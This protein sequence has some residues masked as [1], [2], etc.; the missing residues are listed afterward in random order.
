[1]SLS[2]TCPNGHQ[3]EDM[4]GDSSRDPDHTIP[5][6]VCGTRTRVVAGDEPPPTNQ[7]LPSD[8]P[9]QG[10]RHETLEFTGPAPRL[11]APPVEGYEI[12]SELGRGG[13]GVVYKARHQALKRTV[14]LKMVLG[15]GHNERSLTRFQTEAEAVARLQH[16]NIVQIYEVGQSNG[17]PFFAM[18]FVEGCNLTAHLAGTPQ[19][20][21]DCARLVATLARAMHYAH[22]HGIVHRD[23]KPANILL[24]RGAPAGGMGM[25]KITDFGLAKKLDDAAGPTRTGDVMGTPSYMAPEQALGRL[26]HIGP[27]TD[28]Y[29]L[30]A[31]L[32]ELLT[33]RP[34]FKA[35]TA[36]DTMFQVMYAEPVRPGQL[37]ARMPRDLETICLKC[38]EKEVARRYPSALALAEDLERFVN[39]EPIRARPVGPAGQAMRWARRRPAAAALV[40]V[41]GLALVAALAGSLLYNF[42]QD[43]WNNQEKH[44]NQ[45]LASLA[46]SEKQKAAEAVAERKN[47]ETARDAAINLEKIARQQRLQAERNFQKARQAVDEMLNEV[48]NTHL[49]NVPH[50]DAVRRTLLARAVNFHRSFLET[51][52]SDPSVRFQAAQAYVQLGNIYRK[53]GTEPS[54]RLEA[55]KAYRE[56]IK[57]LTALHGQSAERPGYAQALA[58]AYFQEAQL[59]R[60]VA[61]LT[62]AEQAC[63]KALEIQEQLTRADPQPPADRHALA[64]SL[65]ELG[66]ILSNRGQAKPAEKAY[67][68]ALAIQE[69]L[70]R[71]FPDRP[72]YR[73]FYAGTLNDL[74][75]LYASTERGEEAEK[76]YRQSRD[77]FKALAEKNS[78]VAAYREKLAAVSNNLG[79]ALRVLSRAGAAERELRAA[80]PL[81]EKLA[82]EYP[83]TLSYRQKMA[84]AHNNLAAII[85]LDPQRLADAEKEYNEAVAVLDKLAADF[86]TVPG[87]RSSLAAMLDN[88]GRI[89]SR[90]GKSARAREQFDRAG[91]LHLAVTREKPDNAPFRGFLRNHYAMQAEALLRP[92]DKGDKPHYAE[93]AQAAEQL[94]KL[95][96]NVA[97]E[98][99]LAAT[100]VARCVPLARQDAGAAA[101]DKYAQRAVQLLEDAVQ[102]G[103]QD[104][105][106]LR[107]GTWF[108]EI[109]N[110]ADF[111]KLLASLEKK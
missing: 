66:Q 30:G 78:G 32:Y 87:F 22:E 43:Q 57:L 46:D 61:R 83:A 27:A 88:L 76:V 100:V 96:P 29:A 84:S 90:Q 82:G 21:K 38:L 9:G 52:S 59:L 74:G 10:S 80:L 77:L 72:A 7:L 60:Q 12:L 24:A 79:N 67:R 70:T 2:Y 109:A 50:M 26:D 106:A 65:N 16:P 20:A 6:P 44:L 111:K 45:Q 92:G 103:Y 34:P 104:A 36:M 69:A 3:W 41:S 25:P 40:G 51:D 93:A 89:L 105:S 39:D 85:A 13:M 42:K 5:C 33:A 11:G 19:P 108:G 8:L 55:E 18:E 17:L 71:E 94:P 73:E 28:V 48:G 107:N 63:R 62:E 101:A 81:W 91:A 35:E 49:E 31:I 95:N 53:L 37:R 56:A 47:A 102:H 64:L 99:F 4:W 97:N 98:Y 23:L 68:D 15:G 110:R 14:A 1:M 54:D 58:D 86:P 75:A